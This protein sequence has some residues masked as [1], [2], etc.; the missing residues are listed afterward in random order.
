MV[1]A[2]KKRES[3]SLHQNKEMFASFLCRFRICLHPQTINFMPNF[4]KFIKKMSIDD[5][6]L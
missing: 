4:K 1:G 2:P 3:K 6:N 5:N